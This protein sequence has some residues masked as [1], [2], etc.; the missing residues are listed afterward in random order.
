MQQQEDL[1]PADAW[2]NIIRSDRRRRPI[3]AWFAAV[4]VLTG[5][6]IFMYISNQNPHTESASTP[7]LAQRAA[8]PSAQHNEGSENKSSLQSDANHQQSQPTQNIETTSPNI[9]LPSSTNTSARPQSYGNHPA[10]R[11]TVNNEIA[12]ISNERASYRKHRNTRAQ[13]NHLSMQVAAPDA[14]AQQELSSTKPT[15]DPAIVPADKKSVTQEQALKISVEQPAI[16]EVTDDSKQ[17]VLPMLE[18]N[19]P[20]KPKTKQ[21]VVTGKELRL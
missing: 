18:E 4:A 14:E 6:G 8:S 20:V 12:L 19:P 11:S 5:A 17:P 21:T 2:D 1:V 13:K 3:L 10:S 16:S 7:V 9:N 15:T